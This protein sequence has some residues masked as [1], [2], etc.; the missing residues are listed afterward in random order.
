MA[1]EEPLGLNLHEI[2]FQPVIQAQGSDEQHEIWMPKCLNHEVS[3]RLV[4]CDSFCTNF[5]MIFIGLQII[6]CYMQTELGH[7]SNVQQLETTATYDAKTQEFV[8]ESPTISATK[9]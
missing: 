8:I 3:F 5:D 4:T 1:L 2:A 6:G 7:G 9:W